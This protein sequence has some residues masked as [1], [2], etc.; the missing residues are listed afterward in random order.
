MT[1]LHRAG[2]AAL[3]LTILAMAGA[4][5]GSGER[6]APRPNQRMLLAEEMVAAGYNDAFSAIQSLRPHW[7]RAR[8]ATSFNSQ[9]AVK[10][11]LDGSLMGGLD[12]LKA[13]SVRSI[14]SIRFLDGLEASNR[15]G[16]N[17]GMGA[18]VV[19]TRESGEG[20]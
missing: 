7:M 20:A 15:W 6:G 13:I 5:C 10:V 4:A 14:A 9:E 2:R 1:R 11:Y 17:H 8:G 12:Q 19:S 16:L 18:I 3:L